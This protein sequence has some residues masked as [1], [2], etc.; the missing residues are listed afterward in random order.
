MTPQERSEWRNKEALLIEAS[1]EQMAAEHKLERNEK[2]EI[3]WKIAW[4]LGHSAGL[5]EVEN[6][7]S[8]LVPL[9]K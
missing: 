1:K 2:F 9:L 5:N 7:F 8:D 3:A 4:D 6:Y